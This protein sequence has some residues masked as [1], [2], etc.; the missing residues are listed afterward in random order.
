MVDITRFSTV[1][2]YPTLHRK[3]EGHQKPI[4]IMKPSKLRRDA[5]DQHITGDVDNNHFECA[6]NLVHIVSLWR[7]SRRVLSTTEGQ[8]NIQ[9]RV[10]PE[11]CVLGDSEIVLDESNKAVSCKKKVVKRLKGATHSEVNIKRRK[12]NSV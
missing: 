8:V 3:F 7:T 2:T 5:D 9:Y 6:Q 4:R 10:F 1:V 11:L 12:V